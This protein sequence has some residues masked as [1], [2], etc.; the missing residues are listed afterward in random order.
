MNTKH[1]RLKTVSKY[2]FWGG[3]IVAIL[4]IIS[5]L[6]SYVFSN[7][8]NCESTY[9]GN[10]ACSIGSTFIGETLYNMFVFGAYAFYTIPLG[11]VTSIISGIMFLIACK[12]N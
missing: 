5:I 12:K 1:N 7:V 8:L 2:I 10:Y 11:I 4:P 9:A 3:I 6:L